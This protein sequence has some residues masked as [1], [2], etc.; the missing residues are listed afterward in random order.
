A[1]IY[2]V[3]SYP[4]I[5][6]DAATLMLDDQMMGTTFPGTYA[7][8]VGRSRAPRNP[9]VC[10]RQRK[11]C[12]GR[13]ARRRLFCAAVGRADLQRIRAIPLSA[14]SRRLRPRDGNAR[15]THR[16]TLT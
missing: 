14:A 9:R 5:A 15:G 10:R 7:R 8:W 11:I 13:P 1:A 4:D 6:P 2:V 3:R 16:R 12:A